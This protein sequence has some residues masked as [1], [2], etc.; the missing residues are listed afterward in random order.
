M[1]YT[2]INA[3]KRELG[4]S[5]A[6]L[7]AQAGVT[8]STMDKITSGANQ[9]PT[10]DT[11][12]A[13]ARVLGCTLSDFDDNPNNQSSSLNDRELHLLNHFRLSSI[14][15]QELILKLVR[16]VS[17]TLPNPDTSEVEVV[18]DYFEQQAAIETAAHEGAANNAG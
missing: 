1:N 11:M 10:L 15:G 14:A 17:E 7:A 3:R 5:N 13:I 8:Q 9:N 16:A 2:F 6:Q 4:I 18:R 12:Q